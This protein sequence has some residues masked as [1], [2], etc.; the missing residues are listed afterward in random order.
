MNQLVV[1]DKTT[2]T[3]GLTPPALTFLLQQGRVSIMYFIKY[4]CKKDV[5]LTFSLQIAKGVQLLGRQT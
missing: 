4:I 3:P 2:A 5:T 1:S